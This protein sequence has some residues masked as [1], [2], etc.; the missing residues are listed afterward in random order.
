MP[1][2]RPG[3]I[4]KEVVLRDGRKAVL[5]APDWHDLDDFLALINELVDERVDILRSTH[6]SRS[7]E[8]EWLADR[9][10]AIEKGSLIAL[11]AEVNGRVVASSDVAQRTPENPEHSHVGVL[12]I[13]ILKK[14][15]SVG[16]GKVL[17]N[18]LLQLGKQ[19]GLKVIILDMFATNTTARHLYESVGFIEV[20]KIPKAIHRDGKYIDLVRF[21]IEV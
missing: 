17:M 11:V 2:I 16:L 18:S 9:L 19:A 7:E 10:A 20:G 12:G 6:S 5:R 3:Q 1:V 14:V 15:R 8:T 4:Y 21:A 13:A